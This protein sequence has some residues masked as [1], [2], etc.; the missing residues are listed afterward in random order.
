MS[1]ENVNTE[2]S[3]PIVQASETPVINDSILTSTKKLLGIT[4]ADESFDWDIMMLINSAFVDLKQIAM[5]KDF[6]VTSKTD[7]WSDYFGEL[8]ECAS[9][10]TY[11]FLKVKMV[12][13]PPQSSSVMTAYENTISQLEWRINAEYD[14]NKE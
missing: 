12:F 3:T 8:D 10:K 13:D 9:V 11:V 7:T 6:I 2:Q 5:P 1:E 14:F 4:E